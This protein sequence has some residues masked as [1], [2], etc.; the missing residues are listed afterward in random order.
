MHVTGWPSPCT[1][2]CASG[3]Y[4]CCQKCTQSLGVSHLGIVL[5]SETQVVQ[6]LPKYML[7]GSLPIS[8]G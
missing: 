3:H 7:A 6:D 5:I 8:K 4:T 1:S 2:F